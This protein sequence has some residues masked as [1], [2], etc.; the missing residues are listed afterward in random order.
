ME[1]TSSVVKQLHTALD[2]AAEHPVSA[3][4]GPESLDWICDLHQVRARLD[5]IICRAT[6]ETGSKPL[7][8][9]ET[10]QRSVANHVAA[11]TRG[12]P[13]HPQADGRLGNWL[14]DYPVIGEAFA[15]GQISADHVRAIRA[16]DN[17]R[18]RP[19]LPHSQHN[20]VEA[21]KTC[22]WP[23]F[24]TAL[25]YWENA[26]DPSGEEPAEQVASRQCSYRKRSD[27]TV[28]GNFTLDPIAGHAFITA[29]E[30]YAQTLFRR[31]AEA[32]NQRTAAQRRADALVH[33]VSRGSKANGGTPVP[34]IHL[35]VGA[36][37]INAGL[38]Q[39]DDPGPN[40]GSGPRSTPSPPVVPD[41]D[42]PERRSE[43]IDGTPIHPHF[44][45]AALATAHLR[46]L[47]MGAESE[48]LDLGRTV[49]T[50]PARLK[51]LLLIQSRGR[52][53]H[54]GCNSPHAWLQAD[55]L[56]PWSRE[57]PTSLANGQTLCD[58]HNKQK[59]DKP[60]PDSP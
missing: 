11:R 23:E 56:I 8:T 14:I 17:K 59:R 55:H 36:A 37:I 46:R 21:A 30:H 51:Q 47:V 38:N 5:A 53:Q 32:K 3:L 42:D 52:C 27:G 26:A 28:T 16:R 2:E 43:L 15:A 41:H 19:H 18:T 35:I 20:L 7:T 50:F 29:L 54:P 48:V 22:A 45:L 13:R 12:N 49:R 60:P 44:A 1:P 31:D 39:L 57:G 10:G 58:P 40:P 4:D 33:L 25:R 6:N 34:L 9:G 24:L